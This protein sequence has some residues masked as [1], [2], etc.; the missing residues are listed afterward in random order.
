MLCY[1]SCKDVYEM[2]H[3]IRSSRPCF[4]CRQFNYGKYSESSWE[5]NFIKQPSSSP[6]ACMFQRRSSLW[7]CCWLAAEL[8]CALSPGLLR[9]CRLRSGAGWEVL[10]SGLPCENVRAQGEKGRDRLISDFPWW[11]EL[12]L[13]SRQEQ[14][15]QITSHYLFYYP[16]T[17]WI[18]SSLLYSVL[19]L[20]F[21][22]IN[23]WCIASY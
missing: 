4:V 9:W 11:E 2:P 1:S 15:C 18:H 20:P 17:K 16:G 23:L 10:Q 7:T 3:T 5:K 22:K 19:C 12:F 6:L 8:G 14:L 21:L 13:C